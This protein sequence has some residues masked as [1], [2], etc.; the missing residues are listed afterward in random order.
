MIPKR[1]LPFIVV[2]LALLFIVSLALAQSG[3][4]YDLTWNTVDNGGAMFST[5]GSYSLGGTIGQ[6][7]AGALSGGTYTLT[8]GFWGD[9]AALI[10]IYLPLV[11]K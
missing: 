4:S 5:G 7:E 3:G 2:T 8:G 10:G 6:A 11:M 9:A 1:L